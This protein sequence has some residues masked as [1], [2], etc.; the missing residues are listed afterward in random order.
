LL[1][2]TL[3]II[4]EVVFTIYENPD[5]HFSIAKIKIEDTNEDFDD[6]E[7]VVKG[8]FIQLQK[9]VMYQFFGSLINHKKFGLQY[10]VASYQTFVPET[11]EAVIQYLSS[12]IFPGVGTRTAERIVERLGEQA[13]DKIL[14]NEQ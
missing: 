6:K 4:G 1:T 12:D 8:H 7:I 2:E 13:I 3:Y 10:D 5:E 9:G 11:E 14:H